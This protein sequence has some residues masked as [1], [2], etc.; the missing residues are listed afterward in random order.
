M[1]LDVI[2]RSIRMTAFKAKQHAPEIM[3]IS[4][5][6]GACVGFVMGCKASMKVPAIMEEHANDKKVIETTIS[7]P[8]T[9]KKA[10]THLYLNTTKKF[11][12]NYGPAVT[13]FTLSLGTIFGSTYIFRKR[14]AEYAAAYS[15]ITTAYTQ[16]RNRVVDKFGAEVDNDLLFGAEEIEVPVE[17]KKKPEKK[18][19]Y[20]DPVDDFSQIY[21]DGCIGWT[22]DPVHN[23][24]MVYAFLR[25]ANDKLQRQGYL[26]LE[27]VYKMLGFYPTIVSK[28]A[29]WIYDPEY[30]GGQY[31]IVDFG[32]D[33]PNSLSAARFKE[34][35]E[36]NVNLKFNCI[37]DI[38][39]A[40]VE[41]GFIAFK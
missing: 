12:V 19:I 6:I 14:S 15:A 18:T 10:T 28:K 36:R 39:N 31:G 20:N 37:P 35:L 7:E 16:Y 29:G 38:D 34:G 26:Y 3:A 9:Q 24:Q 30:N 21:Q 4:G 8:E 17:G 2:R 25:M 1:N 27:D 33:D 22:K 41:K 40:V 11:V 13:V 23:K 32:L 5:G